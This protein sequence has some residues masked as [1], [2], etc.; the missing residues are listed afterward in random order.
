M[1]KLTDEEIEFPEFKTL[2]YDVREFVRDLPLAVYDN[3]FRA[4]HKD[5]ER[6]IQY[7]LDF[8]KFGKNCV[9]HCPECNAGENDIDWGDKDWAEESA[10]QKATCQKC[11]CEFAEVYKYSFTE[12][13][14]PVD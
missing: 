2:F 12:T 8:P 6:L 14:N 11:G 10:W 1:D 7:L 3:L 9:N 4:V 13:D 5:K